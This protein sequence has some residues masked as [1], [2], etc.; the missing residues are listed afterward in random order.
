MRED[1]IEALCALHDAR[2]IV[3]LDLAGKGYTATIIHPRDS[4]EIR[5]T[6]V[7]RSEQD[8]VAAVREAWQQFD[9]YQRT[10]LDV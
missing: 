6:F 8:R 3:H 5:L 1:E 4:D 10:T 9:Q 2:L 7:G